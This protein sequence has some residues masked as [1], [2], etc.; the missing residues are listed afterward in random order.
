MGRKRKFGC[1]GSTQALLY[2]AV[3]PEYGPW[4]ILFSNIDKASGSV[5]EY[6]IVRGSAQACCGQS[7]IKKKSFFF[8]ERQFQI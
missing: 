4:F 2:L 3:E 1:V 5:L 8:K 6:L 7:V